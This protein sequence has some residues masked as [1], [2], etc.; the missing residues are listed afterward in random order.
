MPPDTGTHGRASPALTK[1]N[2]K[3]EK[4]HQ[5]VKTS[6]ATAPRSWCTSWLNPS[7]RQPAPSAACPSGSARRKRHLRP[8]PQRSRATG[9]GPCAAQPRTRGPSG[10]EARVLRVNP[11][12]DKPGTNR[13]PL[14]ALHRAQRPAA[15][16]SGHTARPAPPPAAPVTTLG[17]SGW[18]QQL[19]SPTYP[20]AIQASKSPGG[21]PGARTHSP[22]RAR[23]HQDG[24]TKTKRWESAPGTGGERARRRETNSPALLERPRRDS[25]LTRAEEK[26][27]DSRG[28]AVKR[29]SCA[30][31]STSS[32]SLSLHSPPTPGHA[33]SIYHAAYEAGSFGCA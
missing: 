13:C 27:D 24:A 18:D 11:A 9:P 29:T 8:L 10:S 20:K 6:K 33:K 12:R 17:K 23:G 25:S 28:A 21:A 4:Q 14:P 31:L 22:Q 15:R 19:C 30:D 32:P 7:H 1:G 5:E 26:G 2:Q 3:G 16:P